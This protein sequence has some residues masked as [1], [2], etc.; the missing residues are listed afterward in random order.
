MDKYAKLLVSL[1]QAVAP[2]K[3]L[4]IFSAEVKE[5]TGESCTIILDGLELTEVRL[6]STI[7]GSANKIILS[8]KVGS[9]V[10]VGSLTGD[11]KD[12]AVLKID[13]V[14]KVEYVQD[15]LKIVI[16]TTDKKVSIENEEVSFLGLMQELTGLLKDFRVYTPSGASGTPLPATVLK[17]NEF[18]GHLQQ[19]FK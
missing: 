18:E 11:L 17:I 6:K 4:P 12:L 16:D 9:I 1:K 14:E 8:P 3:M 7:N 19:L 13:E 5:I 15:G 10:L 2:P